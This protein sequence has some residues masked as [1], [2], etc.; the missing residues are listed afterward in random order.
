MWQSMHVCEH[1][2]LLNLCCPLTHANRHTHSHTKQSEVGWLQ[3]RRQVG[4]DQKDCVCNGCHVRAH[5]IHHYTHM[6][7]A[8]TSRI[9]PRYR[10]LLKTLATNALMLL[11]LVW[12]LT[13]VKMADTEECCLVFTQCTRKGSGLLLIQTWWSSCKVLKTN[14]G[15]T[16]QDYLQLWNVHAWSDYLIANEHGL[17]VFVPSQRPAPAASLQHALISG[18]LKKLRLLPPA[19]SCFFALALLPPVISKRQWRNCQHP[20]PVS[21][22][23]SPPIFPR[24]TCRT[25]GHWT[26]NSFLVCSLDECNKAQVERRRKNK[27][28]IAKDSLCQHLSWRRSSRYYLPTKE[29]VQGELFN[30]RLTFACSPLANQ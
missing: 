15:C 5:L 24:S 12:G 21:P 26:L 19:P 6:Q 16:P 25:F 28:A 23:P 3:A 20:F 9:P 7:T 14:C 8:P 1:P 30:A 2:A 29:A 11:T 17:P 4:S 13:G 10:T 22:P 27:S 18:H